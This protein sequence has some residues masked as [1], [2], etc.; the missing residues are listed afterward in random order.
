MC[1]RRAACSTVRSKRAI[2][3]LTRR[4]SSARSRCSTPKRSRASPPPAAPRKAA[5]RG[6]GPPL[7]TRSSLASLENTAEHIPATVVRL[8]V[9]RELK[10][11]R[12]VIAAHNRGADVGPH[13]PRLAEGHSSRVARTLVHDEPALRLVEPDAGWVAVAVELAEGQPRIAEPDA[14]TTRSVSKTQPGERTAACRRT[15]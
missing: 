9:Q 10:H 12:R 15:T 5:P 11:R 3:T 6:P 4:A 1:K 13:S 2:H 8:T 14:A 7:S